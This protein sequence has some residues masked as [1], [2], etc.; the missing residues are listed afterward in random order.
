MSPKLTV[1]VITEAEAELA[2]AIQWYDKRR[3]G[4][5]RDLLLEVN[6]KVNQIAEAPERFPV[7]DFPFRVAHLQKF[8]YSLP[9]RVDDDTVT[10]FAV[11]HQSKKPGRWL[12]RQ[13][14][15]EP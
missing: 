8:P 5:G 2:Q 14:Q 15:A 9:F 1:R 12:E 3:P 4:L 10:I 11:M 7:F 6:A 13:H